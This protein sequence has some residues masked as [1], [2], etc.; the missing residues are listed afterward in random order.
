MSEPERLAPAPVREF[1]RPFDIARL[2]EREVVLLIEANAEERAKLAA[3]FDLL[4]LDALSAEL[5]LARRKRGKVLRL[6][7]RLQALVTQSCVVTLDPVESALEAHFSVSFDL[8]GKLHQVRPGEEVE[9][10]PLAED[11]PEP[12]PEEGLDPGEVVA[13]QLALAIDPYPRAVDAILQYD[14]AGAP[15]SVEERERPNPFAALG[16]LKPKD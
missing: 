12:L 8:T 10:D 2:G 6:Q 7:G 9:I 16:A 1:H 14:E 4:S 15:P 3:R 11:L 5:T 13:E